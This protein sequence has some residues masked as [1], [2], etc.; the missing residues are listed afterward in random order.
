MQ[1]PE[2]QWAAQQAP[3]LRGMAYQAE[4][5]SERQQMTADVYG[6]RGRDYSDPVK[7]DRAQRE[8]DRLRSRGKALR[9]TASRAE[10][11]VKPKK[12]GWFR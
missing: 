11:E 4:Q 8:A 5:E 6:R 2:Q 1:T 3:R 7:A 9:D 12:R 10:T